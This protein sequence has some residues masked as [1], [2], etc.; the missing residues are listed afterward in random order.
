MQK[1]LLQYEKLEPRLALSGTGFHKVP[2]SGGNPETVL[3]L[4]FKRTPQGD[5]QRTIVKVEKLVSM[6]SL[7]LPTTESTTQSSLPTTQS[8]LPIENNQ[9]ASTNFRVLS[10]S[11]K[12][13][14]NS[15][16]FISSY[17]SFK[18]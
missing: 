5:L 3:M 2:M 14:S 18:K 12:F 17:K 15:S 10:S 8:G 6:P 13:L 1:N 9:R 4:V 11:F 16:H 7:Q